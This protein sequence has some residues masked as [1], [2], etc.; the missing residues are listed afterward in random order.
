MVCERTSLRTSFRTS[1]R[2]DGQDSL[3]DSRQDSRQNGP[4]KYETRIEVNGVNKLELRGDELKS[5][6]CKAFVALIVE[7]I[8][9]EK[10]VLKEKAIEFAQKGMK[11]DGVVMDPREILEFHDVMMEYLGGI[12]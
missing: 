5:D 8:E 4:H 3:Q 12:K 11:S 7:M 1:L 9:N 6:L 2:T 10:D